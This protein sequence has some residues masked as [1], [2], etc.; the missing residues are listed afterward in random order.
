MSFGERSYPYFLVFQTHFTVSPK[1]SL[2]SLNSIFI[3]KT[4]STE[5]YEGLKRVKEG[6][7][8]GLCVLSNPL[9]IDEL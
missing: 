6:H 4:K 3:D 2:D 9:E 1:I 7:M 5:S 8:N